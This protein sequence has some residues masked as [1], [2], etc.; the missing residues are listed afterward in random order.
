MK[1]YFVAVGM[2]AMLVMACNTQPKD[3]AVQDIQMND[4]A[5]MNKAEEQRP[6]MADSVA[7]P[8][9]PPPTK[10]NQPVQM[11]W[12]KKIIKTADIK[13]EVENYKKANDWLHASIKK[14]G[15]YI[16]T[17]EQSQ[18]DY[19]LQN[20]ITI[21]VPVAQFEDLINSFDG[22]G[23]KLVEKKISSE[24]VTSE[25]IDNKTRLEAKRTIHA[26]YMELLRQAKNM[27]EILEVQQELNGLQEDLEAAGGRVQYLKH[28]AA[29]STIHL[30]F[31]QYLNGN[32]GPAEPGFFLKLGTS[33]KNGIVLIEG[34]LIFIATFWPVWIALIVVF[35]L[36]KRKAKNKK[37]N[38][39][40]L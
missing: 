16:A 30:N 26:R 22:N 9:P 25:Y 8:L 17:E 31:F 13:M 34:L 4:M 19:Q 35:I 29:Y 27:K 7:V 21:K 10:S 2:T 32:A 6:A 20:N 39:L 18:T 38:I 33:F 15:A 12:D 40:T 1:K 36:W 24:D 14:Y 28:Q 37:T 23:N 5:A 11:D 3:K